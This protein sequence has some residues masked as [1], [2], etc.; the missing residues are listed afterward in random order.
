MGA[1][2]LFQILRRLGQGKCPYRASHCHRA[3]WQRKRPIVTKFSV[4]EAALSAIWKSGSYRHPSTGDGGQYRKPTKPECGGCFSV[5][6]YGQ[7]KA[8]LQKPAHDGPHRRL[9]ASIARIYLMPLLQLAN[10]P[11]WEAKR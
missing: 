4:R 5:R 1:A 2:G 8:G 3:C 6:P 9:T 7:S 11:L 10:L